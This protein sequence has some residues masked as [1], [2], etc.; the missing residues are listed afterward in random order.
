VTGRPAMDAA[1]RKGCLVACAAELA[2]A[3]GCATLPPGLDAPKPASGALESPDT[4]SL[5]RSV[6]ARV[7]LHPGLS[8][9]GLLVDGRDRFSLRLRL[10]DAAERTLDVQY[11]VLQQ[12]DTGQLLLQ[13]LLQAADRGVRVRLLLDDAEA[14]DAKSMIRPLAAHPNIHIRIYNPFVARRPLAIL[15][16]AEY[17]L[18]ASRRSDQGK[19]VAQEPPPGLTSLRART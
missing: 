2:L 8:G 19:A 11:F 5:G 9:F 16:G 7:R 17:L 18:E 6:A 3:A 14:F 12:D 1:L 15:R 13:A 4:T 10:A